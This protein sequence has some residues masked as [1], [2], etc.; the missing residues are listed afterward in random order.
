MV[1]LCL[2]IFALPSLAQTAN[3]GWIADSKTGCRVWNS[4]PKPRETISWSGDCKIGLAQGR[5]VLQWFVDGKHGNR[6]EGE[7]RGGQANGWGV[8]T[9]TD[10]SHY[11]GEWKDGRRNGR[12]VFTF[13]NGNRYEGE[14]KDGNFNGRGDLRYADG[15]RYVG[16]F[17]DNKVN[18][19]G[20]LIVGGET[21][22]GTWT[23][24]CYREGGQ[25]AVIGTTRKECGFE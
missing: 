8:Y 11:D 21:Y 23:N 4:S 7:Y 6:Y 15:T 5:G 10:G 3:P 12:G 22:S 17:K 24:G 25:I 1:F 19:T 16:E 20:V 13:T 14:F 9:Y 18:G 2:M